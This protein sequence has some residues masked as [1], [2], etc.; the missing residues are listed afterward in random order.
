[1]VMKALIQ[2]AWELKVGWDDPLPESVYDTWLEWR[3][4]L[5]CLESLRVPR[6]YF[7]KELVVKRTE[8][9]GFSDTSEVAYG[10][11]IVSE[12]YLYKWRSD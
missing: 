6:C 5:A 12:N 10:G 8:L 7:H 3:N 9:H 11:S 2:K 4:Q 1:M